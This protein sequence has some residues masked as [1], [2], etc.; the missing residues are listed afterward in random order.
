M[1]ATIGKRYALIIHNTRKNGT[2]AGVRRVIMAS[3][4]KPLSDK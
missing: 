2:N 3:I 4:A 1:C